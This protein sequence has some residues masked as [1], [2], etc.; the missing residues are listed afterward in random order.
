M[1]ILKITDVPADAMPLIESLKTP[2]AC[3]I[4]PT[5]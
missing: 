4:R 2:T 3:A 5:G 1:T